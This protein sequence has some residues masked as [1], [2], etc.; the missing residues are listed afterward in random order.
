M[1]RTLFIGCS[2]SM[3]YQGFLKGNNKEES[4]QPNTWGSNNYAEFYSKIHNKKCV[5][6][7]S[8]GT[9]N[10]VYPRF[11]AHAFQT[12][13]DID[14]VFIQSTYWGRF[15]IVINPDLDPTKI[16]PTDFFL[17]KDTSDDLVDRW[18]IAL[19]VDNKYL[20][21]YH[22]PQPQDWEMFP[23]HRD[24]A[25]W[26]AEPDTRRSSHLY[27]QMWHY[28]N[29][30]LEQEDYF[31]DIAVCDMICNNNNV[32]MYVWNINN[33]C[34]IPQETANYYTKLNKTK[35]ASQNAETFFNEKFETLDGEHYTEKVH[36]QIAEQYIPILKELT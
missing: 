10:R 8:A 21:H 36:K 16:F 23:Y 32:P 31:K 26:V 9:G 7:A 2:H 33:R 1:S 29:T 6:M 22:K 15:P 12:Y 24:T 30:H 27:F 35:F 4:S 19:S 34:F 13:D 3:G 18:S 11:L 14:E 28:Q 20:E 25:P 17:Q 5:V